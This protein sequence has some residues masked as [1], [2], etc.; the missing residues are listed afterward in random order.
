M[1]EEA[2]HEGSGHDIEPFGE[3]TDGGERGWC[4]EDCLEECDAFGWSV[5]EVGMKE[6]NGALFD[7]AHVFGGDVLSEFS[8]SGRISCI[9]EFIDAIAAE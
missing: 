6:L 8:P 5:F 9:D 1:S 7:C 2:A 4:E 3:L